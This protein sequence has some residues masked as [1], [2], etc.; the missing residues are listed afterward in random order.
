MD[1]LLNPEVIKAAASSPLG[2]LSLMC[3]IIGIVSLGLFRKAPV[4]AKL[5]VFVLLLAGVFGFGASVVH[6]QNPQPEGP[7]EASRD[8]VVGRWQVE[9]TMAGAEGGTF[10]DY[11]SDGRFTGKLEAFVNG[12][13]RREPVSGT[14]D[15]AK[16]AKDQFKLELKFDSG[17]RWNGTFRI[18]DRDHIHNLNENYVAVRVVR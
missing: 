15:L 6:Q 13:G 12:A 7:P 14:W 18:L 5:I 10:V 9:Q 16:L 11:A 4:W 1:N 8:F 3:L 17:N 2:I